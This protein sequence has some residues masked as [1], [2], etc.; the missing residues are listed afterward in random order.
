MKVMSETVIARSFGKHIEQC[1][2]EE[3]FCAACAACELVCALLH[4]GV[5]GHQ[6]KRIFVETGTQ[7]LQS[8]VFS[9]QHCSDHPCYNACPKKDKAMCLD[10]QGIAYIVESECI[11]CRQCSKHC[12]FSPPRLNYVKSTDKT[13]RKTKKCDLCRTR[14]EGPACVQYC[15]VRCLRVS[16]E[17]E[18]A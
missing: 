16:G 6:H 8:I 15:Q 5:T 17:G 1:P 7:S 14:P 13:K 12:V 10:D 18:G 11:G 9:C 4:D 3:S 2:P